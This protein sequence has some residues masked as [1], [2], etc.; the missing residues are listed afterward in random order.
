VIV[1]RSTVRAAATLLS[2][3]TFH[4]SRPFLSKKNSNPKTFRA[5]VNWVN[6]HSHAIASSGISAFPIF[7]LWLE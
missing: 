1:Y 2:I 4:L 5:L 3:P 6:F 7:D